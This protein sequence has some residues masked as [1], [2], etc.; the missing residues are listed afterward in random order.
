MER[1]LCPS[2]GVPL[3]VEAIARVWAVGKDSMSAEWGGSN[4]P[5]MARSSPSD[6]RSG[7]SGAGKIEFVFRV[8]GGH[9]FRLSGTFHW[10]R[11]FPLLVAFGEVRSANWTALFVRPTGIGRLLHPAGYGRTIRW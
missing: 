10:K 7:G 9:V 11:A 4:A 3:D 2:L 8:R 6:P 1:E 5:G